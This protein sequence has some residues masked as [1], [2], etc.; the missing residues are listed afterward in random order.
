M[1]WEPNAEHVKKLADLKQEALKVIP[2]IFQRI[3]IT[4]K[5]IPELTILDD[6]EDL[7]SGVR[8]DGWID[9]YPFYDVPDNFKGDDIF[10]GPTVRWD[11]VTEHVVHGT[12]YYPDGSGEPDSCDVISIY[13]DMPKTKEWHSDYYN[14]PLSMQRACLDAILIWIKWY[15]NQQWECEAEDEMVKMELEEVWD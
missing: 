14:Y 9:V 10:G 6:S 5:N 12:R 1:Y 8:I 13:E 2:S 15:V 11:V 4:G 7:D 3:G